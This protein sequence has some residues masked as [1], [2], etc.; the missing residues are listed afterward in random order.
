MMNSIRRFVFLIAVLGFA[1]FALSTQ[2][3]EFCNGEREKPLVVQFE[4][5]QLV[6]VGHFENA[7]QSA[8]G[9]ASGTTD[10]VIER[11]YKDHPMVK[12]LTKINLPRYIPNSKTKFII[13]GEIYKG[14]I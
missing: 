1:G 9:I 11:V 7:R 10:F 8:D 12:G 4:D 6:L 5:A 13:F 2:A 3:C 14:K